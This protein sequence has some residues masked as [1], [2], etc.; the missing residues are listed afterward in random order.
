M[1]KTSKLVVAALAL[2]LMG[3]A[4]AQNAPTPPPPP[5]PPPAPSTD[6]SP[7]QNPS[8]SPKVPGVK[9]ATLQSVGD[10]TPFYV[11]GG[12]VV[13]GGIVAAANGGSSHSGQSTS[14]TTGTH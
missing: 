14:G 10:M 12:V 6:N 2:S 13:V 4:L 1:N 8:A 3:S 5:A 11:V 7:T 9:D